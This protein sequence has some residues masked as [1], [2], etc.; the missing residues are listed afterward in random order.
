[1]PREILFIL[2]TTVFPLRLMPL[3]AL[4]RVDMRLLIRSQD[5]TFSLPSDKSIVNLQEIR[6]A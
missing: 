3:I 2:A 5:L 1:M 4:K 6:S